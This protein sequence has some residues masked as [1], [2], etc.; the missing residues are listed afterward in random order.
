MPPAGDTLQEINF[1]L[2]LEVELQHI[3]EQLATPEACII[4]TFFSSIIIIFGN[5][6]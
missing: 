4:F 6:L 3:N 2:E 5:I 1:W